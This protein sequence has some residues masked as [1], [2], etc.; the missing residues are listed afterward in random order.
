MLGECNLGI[1][2]QSLEFSIILPVY[3]RAN[4]VA[5]AIKSVVA[6]A[7]DSWELL[8]ID[9]GSVD[10]SADVIRS[11]ADT[12]IH[13]YSQTNQGAAAARNLGIKYS[14][15]Q[16]VCFLDSDDALDP[17]FLKRI[18]DKWRS[19]PAEVG[20]LWTG[21]IFH[22]LVGGRTVTT[23]E[24]WSPSIK[25]DPYHTF[26]SELRIGTN[27]GISVR[28]IVF[29]HIGMFD[30]DLPAAEDTEFFLRLARNYAF[31][32]VPA[33][34]INIHQGGRD[35]LSLRFDRIAIAYNRFIPQHLPVIVGSKA[36]RLKFFY[37][38]MWLNYHL[39]EAGHAREYFRK[40]LHDNMLHRKGWMVFLIFE[41]FGR[42][43]GARLHTRLS[44]T[45]RS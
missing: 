1:E 37:K 41:T 8:A 31:D 17:D 18:Y 6:Q 29:D 2:D 10:E 28:R 12:R 19:A 35:R 42:R 9:D 3:N 26:L 43:F 16:F 25:R 27:S 40:L 23:S 30:P 21:C 15:G 7:I 14:R 11:F 24:L 45:S 32:H 20:M 4:S 13:L 33:Y 22:R 39:G 34:L 44:M 38:L 5:R 36:L